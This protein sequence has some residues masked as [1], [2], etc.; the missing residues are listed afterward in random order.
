[1]NEST[2]TSHG[3]RQGPPLRDKVAEAWE[4][5]QERSASAYHATEEYLGEHRF[6]A[7]LG[8][9]GLGFG[10]GLLAG[11]RSP[12]E[13]LDGEATRAAAHDAG[14]GFFFMKMIRTFTDIFIVAGGLLLYHE[15]QQK[16]KARAEA[17][18]RAAAL[19]AE[20]ERKRQEAEALMRQAEVRAA[21][22]RTAAAQQEKQ[23]EDVLKQATA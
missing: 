16:Q 1:M 13:G 5:A 10:L 18:R 3:F 6:P 9:L 4:T 20:A 21:A 23:A 8:A 19:A 12:D 7:V 22:A 14:G 2:N 17:E 15:M 11:G